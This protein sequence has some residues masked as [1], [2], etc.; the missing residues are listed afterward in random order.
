MTHHHD[1]ATFSPALTDAE[2]RFM[3]HMSRWGSDGYPVDKSRNGW[4]WA[5]FCGIKGSPVV[6]R[7][8][9]AAEAAIEC[10]IDVLTDKIAG[11]C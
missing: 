4:I 8:R 3:R 9:R 7:T 2:N 11:R 6:Y 1:N 5:E 10:Y